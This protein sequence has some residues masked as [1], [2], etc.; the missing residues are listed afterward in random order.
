MEGGVIAS[1][2]MDVEGIRRGLEYFG[3]G[4]LWAMLDRRALQDDLADNL[5]E[6]G[7]KNNDKQLSRYNPQ[8]VAMFMRDA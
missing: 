7:T 1:P 6:D 2:I 3:G 5:R 8:A 4:E